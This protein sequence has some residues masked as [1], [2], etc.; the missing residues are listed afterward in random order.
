[1]YYKKGWHKCLKFDNEREN[2]WE[3]F[4]QKNPLDFSENFHQNGPV[5]NGTGLVLS[6]PDYTGPAMIWN[7]LWMYTHTVHRGIY[8]EKKIFSRLQGGSEMHDQNIM[9]FKRVRTLC[10]F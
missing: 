4:P 10:I 5:E 7:F 9:I 2:F 6:S 3:N 1:M 8:V